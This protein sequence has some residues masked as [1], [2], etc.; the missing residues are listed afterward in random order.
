MLLSDIIAMKGC[1]TTNI[2]C[3][4][5]RRVDMAEQFILVVYSGIHSRCNPLN[6]F[7][8]FW[9]FRFAWINYS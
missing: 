4:T 6:F 2:D 1:Y 7:F 3:S 9:S 5:L 8:E